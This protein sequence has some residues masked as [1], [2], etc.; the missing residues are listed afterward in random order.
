MTLNKTIPQAW[1]AFTKN[2][3]FLIWIILLEFVFLFFLTQV[4]LY[5]FQPTS[6][7]VMK[8]GEIMSREL[9]KLPEAEIF[10]LEGILTSNE[11]FM[12]AYKVL[13]ANLGL[14]ILTILLIWIIFRGP[15]WYFSYKSIHKKIPLTT[16]WLKFALLSL[17]WFTAL[18]GAF[19]IY[20]ISTGS[21]ATLL[22]IATSQFTT[23]LMFLVFFVIYYFSQVS[24]ALV[25]AQQTFKK[26]FVYGVKHA[27]TIFPAL[28]VNAI[29]MFV[30]LTLPFNW[31]QTKP[32]LSL[33]IILFITIPAL[34]FTRIHI[35]VATWLKH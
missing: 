16:S 25:P 27:K 14:F 9:E 3:K 35:I 29:I 2:K 23:F 33:A 21:T 30:V 24:F 31:I 17:M 20:S 10:Q 22:P 13:L 12:A 8:T 19:V 18:V 7:A 1:K 32:L 28:I 11:Q 34:A 6:E 4:H 5:Y 26:T 15:V